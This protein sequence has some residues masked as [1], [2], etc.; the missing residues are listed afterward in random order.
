[1]KYLK[2]THENLVL[3]VELIVEYKPVNIKKQ[4]GFEFKN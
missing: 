4:D 3:N 2:S 1:M